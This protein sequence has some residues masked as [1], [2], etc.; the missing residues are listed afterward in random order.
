MSTKLTKQIK[1]LASGDVCD[2]Q[3]TLT[4][5]FSKTS[6]LAY[7]GNDECLIVRTDEGFKRVKI[8]EIENVVIHKV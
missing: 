6:G 2:V 4:T 7:G 8:E 1:K 5:S 3:V